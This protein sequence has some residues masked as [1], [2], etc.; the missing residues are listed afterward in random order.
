VKKTLFVVDR[1]GYEL[2]TL[3]RVPRKT[4]AVTMFVKRH[5]GAWACVA[6]DIPEFWQKQSIF[7]RIFDSMRLDKFFALVQENQSEEA[8]Y[9]VF[10]QLLDVRV[11]L[12]CNQVS[13]FWHSIGNYQGLWKY[14]CN[15]LWSSKVYIPVECTELRLRG[16]YKAALLLS[17]ADCGRVRMTLEELTSRPLYFRFKASAGSFWTEND[18]YWNGKDAIQVLEL[19]RLLGKLTPQLTSYDTIFK[20]FSVSL[21]R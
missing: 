21:Y 15:D 4:G 1:F 11:L 5:F 2:V 14:L 19:A 6:G 8:L 12:L 16:E 3:F 13:K 18:P 20:V 7:L 9:H 17:L 10:L